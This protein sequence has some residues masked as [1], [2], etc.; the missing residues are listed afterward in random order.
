MK[1]IFLWH[2][3]KKIKP[4]G[5]GFFVEDSFIYAIGKLS[6]EHEV[7][8]FAINKNSVDKEVWCKSQ[9][10]RYKFYSTVDKLID[11]V[12]KEQPDI[13][14]YNHHP[15]DFY[16]IRKELNLSS[17]IKG[18]YFSAPITPAPDWADMNILMVHHNCHKNQLIQ[19]GVPETNIWVS[20]KTANEK[21]FYPRK[22]EKKWDVIYPARGG[23]GYWKRLE[24]IVEAC[25]LA[26]L[27]LVIPGSN[28][29]A[30]DLKHVTVLPWLTPEELAIAYNQSRCL[31]VTSGFQ[32]MGPRIIPEAVMCNIPFVV[33]NDSPAGVSHAQR[34]GGLISKP[35]PRDFAKM[36]KK[37]VQ[38]NNDFRKRA[39][40]LGMDYESNYRVLKEILFRFEQKGFKC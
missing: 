3:Q 19:L 6:Q 38:L 14:F 37:A 5:T 11:A 8:L 27:S 36:L 4:D 20:P 24:L 39:L 1:I 35:N 33:C 13:L 29:D 10:I 40:E 32:E 15:D 22:I 7:Y 28:L 9:N 31:A 16:N 34:L 30:T 26:K 21:I 2:W 18:I 12:K 23:L 25:K 17:K